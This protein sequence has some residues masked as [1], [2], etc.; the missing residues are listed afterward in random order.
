MAKRLSKIFYRKYEGRRWRMDMMIDQKKILAL[1]AEMSNS[2]SAVLMSL[3]FAWCFCF[4]Q[5]RFK[6]R[7]CSST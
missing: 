7:N 2:I 4:Q 1:C 5:L 3:D 6:Q